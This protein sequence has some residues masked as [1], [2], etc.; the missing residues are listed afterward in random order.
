MTK[1]KL[2]TELNIIRIQALDVAEKATQLINTAGAS[3]P[4]SP[5]KRTQNISTLVSK[6]NAKIF[7]KNVS[8][9]TK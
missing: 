6:R 2:I 4:A 5:T 1:A 7:G 8:F 9:T 3:A